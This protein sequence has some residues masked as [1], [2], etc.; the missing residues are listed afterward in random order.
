MARREKTSEQVLLTTGVDGILSKP[1]PPKTS[2]GQWNKKVRE[3]RRDA[4][5]GFLRDLF[6]APMLAAEWTVVSDEGFKDGEA[7]V[8]KCVLPRHRFLIHHIVRGLLD[9]GWQPFEMVHDYVDDMIVLAKVKPL[10]Q[11]ITE[12]VVDIHGNLIGLRNKPTYLNNLPQWAGPWV[13]VMHEEQ[14]T[15]YTDVEG[16]NWYGEPRMYRAEQPYDSWLTCEASAQRFDKKVAG[17][18]WIVHYPDGRS[19]FR[20]EEEVENAEIAKA[21][22]R[23]LESSGSVAVPRS[24]AKEVE[25]LDNLSDDKLGWKIELLS[26]STNTASSFVDRQKYQD[27]LKARAIGIP[28]RAVFEG[29]FGTKAEAEAH[30]D[31]AIDAIEGFHVDVVDR[32]NETEVDFLLEVN[33]GSSY[34]GRVKVKASPLSDVDRAKMRELYMAWFGSPDGAASEADAVD[35]D[36]VRQELGIPTRQ[37]TNPDRVSTPKV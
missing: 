28:E 3:M 10:L 30:A 14:V 13:E 23:E 24:V 11:D 1:R 34:K 33:H 4:T 29:Q 7:I 17:A 20:G 12:I 2:S 31:F 6:K 19:P 35:F 22:L 36:A 5:L 37:D 15:F 27:A 26:A 9:F 8:E 16:T 25:D 18:H 21:I 32:L